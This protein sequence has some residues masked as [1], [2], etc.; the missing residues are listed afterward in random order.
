MHRD[1]IVVDLRLDVGDNGPMTDRTDRT[2]D[3]D[4]QRHTYKV[5]T[6]S[7]V[8]LVASGTVIFSLLEHW[9][10]VDSL[11][12]CVVTVTTV[13]FGDITPDT[14]VAKLFT[15]V[16]IIFGISIISTFLDARLKKHAYERSNRADDGPDN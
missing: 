8:F 9:S 16:Y 4:F 5:L 12:F 13:G 3:P 7:A 1:A 10:I 14:D 2:K 15:V 6:A 11:Y